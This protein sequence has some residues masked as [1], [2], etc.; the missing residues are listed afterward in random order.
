M[1][2]AAIATLIVVQASGCGNLGAWL[3]VTSL[4][5]SRQLLGHSDILKDRNISE[6][7]QST[8]SVLEYKRINSRFTSVAEDDR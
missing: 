1:V 7:S 2:T 3:M 8:C 5:N 6:A 4:G